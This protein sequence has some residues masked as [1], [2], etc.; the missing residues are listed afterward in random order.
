MSPER[1]VRTSLLIQNLHF[2]SD[3]FQGLQRSRAT[4]DPGDEDASLKEKT[5]IN[6]GHL[7]P[8][9]WEITNGAYQGWV[10]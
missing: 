9:F 4:Q 7:A 10:E 3:K 6:A 5:L 8:R 1:G 2:R